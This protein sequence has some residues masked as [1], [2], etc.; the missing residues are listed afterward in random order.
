MAFSSTITL[1]TVGADVTN[2]SLEECTGEGTNCTPITGYNNVSTT[3][4]PVTITT[5]SDTTTH[6]KVTALSPCSTTQNVAIT[7]IPVPLEDD[8]TGN[9][10][11]NE[12][13]VANGDHIE[14]VDTNITI[15]LERA[16]GQTG[17]W[18]KGFFITPNASINPALTANGF[19]RHIFEFQLPGSSEWVKEVSITPNAGSGIPSS[20]LTEASPYVIKV[21][22]TG[23][24]NETE[25]TF[26]P[27]TIGV[28][29]DSNDLDSTAKVQVVDSTV[30]DAG[31]TSY[32][33]FTAAY[34]VDGLTATNGMAFAIT[35][36]IQWYW[37]KFIVPGTGL[38][39][40]TDYV[41]NPM[42]GRFYKFNL[43]SSVFPNTGQGVGT[44][45]D[46]VFRW[47]SVNRNN[48]LTN[49]PLVNFKM[50]IILH[51]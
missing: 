40:A 19:P 7:G 35:D 41:N 51:N 8:R 39:N 15:T 50:R 33:G 47:Y 42:I 22:M 1:G 5:L 4:F 6:I 25:L 31:G 36:G 20:V 30:T 27:L 16:N 10:Y 38:N 37:T 11:L 24:I 2:V 12:I 18:T 9:Q 28:G 32:D 48:G 34:N 14:S 13:Y 45:E 29:T 44:D 21:R 17:N 49:P 43:G 23:N 26:T 3:S 46:R